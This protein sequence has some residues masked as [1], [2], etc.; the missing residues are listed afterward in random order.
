MPQPTR[1]QP[2]NGVHDRI[3]TVTTELTPGRGE[4]VPAS[5]L[6]A[7]AAFSHRKRA[8]CPNITSR[9]KT[10][11][12]YWRIESKMGNINE[13]KFVMAQAQAAIPL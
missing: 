5:N 11:L 6:T 13:Q 3:D 9:D 10:W 1:D 12:P 7:I 4:T 2:L 8:Q